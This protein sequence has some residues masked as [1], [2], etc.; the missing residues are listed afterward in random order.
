MSV[1]TAESLDIARRELHKNLRATRRAQRRLL[2]KA[3]SLDSGM[4]ATRKWVLDDVDI[5]EQKAAN[6]ERR[7]RL[8]R[9]A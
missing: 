3:G 2:R 7:L 5:L 1:A 4:A 9:G 6:I 8:E